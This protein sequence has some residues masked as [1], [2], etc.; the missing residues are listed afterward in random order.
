[1]LDNQN[2]S[3]PNFSIPSYTIGAT[4]FDTASYI[5]TV[6]G[7]ARGDTIDVTD[8]N[9]PGATASWQQNGASGTLTISNGTDTA[10][11]TACRRYLPADF[12]V[13]A[14]A[15]G[16]GT[17]VVFNPIALPPPQQVVENTPHAISG[18]SID[19]PGAGSNSLTVT[20]AVN[21]GTLIVASGVTGGLTANE[22]SGNGTNS[23][24]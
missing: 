23:S 24:R 12:V 21:D 20:L 5:G 16:N 6:S 17:D 18:L 3:G 22:I 9:A 4:T 8:L 1:M 15:S 10:T 11:V 19:D 2:Q 7:F 13:A 14:D